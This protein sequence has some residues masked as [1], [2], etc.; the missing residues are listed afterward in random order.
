MEEKAGRLRGCL[1]IILPDSPA[2][3]PSPSG[4]ICQGEKP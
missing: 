4:Q 3:T 2:H 1:E